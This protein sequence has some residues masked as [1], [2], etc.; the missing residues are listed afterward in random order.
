[1]DVNSGESQLVV[2]GYIQQGYPAYVFLTRTE[3]YFDPISINTLDDI[4]KIE[5]ESIELLAGV[6][7]KEMMHYARH[8][9]RSWW[10]EKLEALMKQNL[11][12][13]TILIE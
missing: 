7:S 3:G 6:A 2:E 9:V 11:K 10:Q 12:Y 4:S 13:E 8:L 5:I 1:M